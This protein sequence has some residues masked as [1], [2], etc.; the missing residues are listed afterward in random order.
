M[1]TIHLIGVNHTN[2]EETKLIS[3]VIHSVKPDII[4][5][6]RGQDTFKLMQEGIN[7]RTMPDILKTRIMDYNMKGRMM[8]R[9]LGSVQMI[10][11]IRTGTLFQSV[12][13]TPAHKMGEAHNIDVIPIDRDISVTMNKLGDEVFNIS[14]IREYREKIDKVGITPMHLDEDDLQS[15]RRYVEE[16]RSVTPNVHSVMVDERDNIMVENINQNIQDGDTGVVVVGAVHA[17]GMI[18]ILQDMGYN[19]EVHL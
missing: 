11:S 12:D 18:D 6:E 5:I 8:H 15:L 3:E 17:P 13:M 4:F 7:F 2:P 14:N 1:K 16:R 10:K 19:I 9:L